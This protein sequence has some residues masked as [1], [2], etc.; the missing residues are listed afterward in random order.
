MKR[1]DFKFLA[2][3]FILSSNALFSQLKSYSF[4][5][6]EV[7]QSVENK[8]VVVFVSTVWC[9]YCKVMENVTFKD[10]NVMKNLND[11]FYFIQLN[12]EEKTSIRFAGKD[13]HYQPTGFK[14][15]IHQLAKE[16]GT[17]NGQLNFPTLV[18]L[19][20]KNEILFQYSGF[21]NQQDFNTIL[22]EF[23]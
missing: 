14:T 17:I 2:L 23:Q 5:Q 4:N 15:G 11:N 10:K 19:N 8:L 12:A 21:I 7:L 6:V 18:I 20:S 13:F 3:I 22:K 1:L 16:L 9:Q